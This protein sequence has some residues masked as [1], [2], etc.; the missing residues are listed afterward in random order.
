MKKIKRVLAVLLA[1]I[2]ALGT[3][4]SLAE[5]VP[6]ADPLTLDDLDRLMKDLNDDDVVYIREDEL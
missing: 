5:T 1:L 3:V 2:L 4:A 6:T